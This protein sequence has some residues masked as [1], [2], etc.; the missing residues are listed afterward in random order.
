ML[1]QAIN[2]NRQAQQVFGKFSLCAEEPRAQEL[3]KVQNTIKNVYKSKPIVLCLRP[4][5]ALF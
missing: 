1:T 4:M 5:K 2:S 3:T